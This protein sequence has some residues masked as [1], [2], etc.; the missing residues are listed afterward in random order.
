MTTHFNFSFVSFIESTGAPRSLM[1][2]CCEEWMKFMKRRST[3]CAVL[4]DVSMNSHLN[5]RANAAPSSFGTSHSWVMSHLLPMSMKMGFPRL[6]LHIDWQR[7]LRRLNVDFEAIEYTRMNPCSVLNKMACM[8]KSWIW[9]SMRLV[10]T[11]TVDHARSVHVP[12]WLIHEDRR[13]EITISDIPWPPVSITSTKHI[14]L[15]TTSCFR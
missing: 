13:V 4:A 14:W 10:L 6:S 7:I 2:V 9:Q 3:F 12:L 1:W 5:W 11:V 15:S 8:S